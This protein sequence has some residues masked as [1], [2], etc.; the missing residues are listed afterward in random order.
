VA[1]VYRIEH[2]VER[3]GPYGGPE[4]FGRLDEMQYAHSDRSHPNPYHDGG[5]PLRGD[6]IRR[7]HLFAF[8]SVEA[9]RTWFLGF[10]DLLEDCDYVLATYAVDDAHIIRGRRQLV[11]DGREATLVSHNRPTALASPQLRAVI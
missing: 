2:R 6:E 3:S 1:L 4:S 7:Y 11:Y 10:L 9:L 5:F 8:D